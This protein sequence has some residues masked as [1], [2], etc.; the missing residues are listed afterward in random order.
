[1]ALARVLCVRQLADV[2][3][4]FPRPHGVGV[5]ERVVLGI[6]TLSTL[7]ILYRGSLHDLGNDI[8]SD[9]FQHLHISRAF[10]HADKIL[11]GFRVFVRLPV[12]RFG[13]L[14]L[15]DV[16]QNLLI[17]VVGIRDQIYRRLQ[18]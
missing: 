14:L 4:E 16:G 2:S 18:D 17:D 1:M 15:I 11:K 7:D 6:Q 3:L 8:V 13:V 12:H 5:A 10:D 9:M